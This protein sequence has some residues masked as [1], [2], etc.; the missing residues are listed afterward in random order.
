MN[1]LSQ[2]EDK[3]RENDFRFD[4]ERAKEAAPKIMDAVRRI[5]FSEYLLQKGVKYDPSLYNQEALDALL[6]SVLGIDENKIR[7]EL[8]GQ[9]QTPDVIANRANQYAQSIARLQQ[10]QIVMQ[11]QDYDKLEEARKYIVNEFKKANIEVIHPERIDAQRAAGYLVAIKSGEYKRDDFIKSQP[12]W[13]K[14][15]EPPKQDK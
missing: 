7:D 3:L 2:V 13:L 1:Y 6:A 4:P 5:F 12:G 15:Y 11:L 10:G 8:E 9:Q 14:K